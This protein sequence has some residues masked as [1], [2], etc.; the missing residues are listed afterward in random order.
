MFANI[1]LCEPEEKQRQIDYLSTTPVAGIAE[2]LRSGRCVLKKGTVSSLQI[3]GKLKT[4]FGSIGPLVPSS[5][6]GEAK[7]LV[8]E[9]VPVLRA[10]PEVCDDGL[11]KNIQAIIE[12]EAKNEIEF[13][14]TVLLLSNEPILKDGNKRTISFFENRKHSNQDK[15]S[16]EMFLV[17]PAQNGT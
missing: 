6:T 2:L 1:R 17:E 11:L 7:F 16:Y 12:K 3:L 9:I 8:S 14:N 13:N 15:I 4:E 5:K 10:N